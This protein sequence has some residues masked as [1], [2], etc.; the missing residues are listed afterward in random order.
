MASGQVLQISFKVL[1]KKLCPFNLRLSFLSVVSISHTSK[2]MLKILQA[3]L[4]QYVNC[5][6]SDV[7][8]ALR[9]EIK[10]PTSTGS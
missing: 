8:A 9:K 1:L 10:L 7:Q 5:E 2:V 4:Q 3:R 6:F